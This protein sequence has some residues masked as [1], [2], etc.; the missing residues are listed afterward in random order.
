M[1]QKSI[2]IAEDTPFLLDMISSALAENEQWNVQT[3]ADGQQAIDAMAVSQPDLLILDIL[4]PNVD[5]YEVLAHIAERGYTFP[6][7]VLTNLSDDE[8]VRRCQSLG[9]KEVWVKSDIDED[10]LSEKVRQFLG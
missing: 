9:A 7:V 2:L 5:G 10:M 6:V 4:M 3:A 8:C 1:E